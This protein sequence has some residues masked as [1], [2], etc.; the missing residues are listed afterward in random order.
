ML[1]NS[2][3]RM[4]L[5]GGESVNVKKDSNTTNSQ[6]RQGPLA[7]IGYH[8]GPGNLR[9]YNGQ[10]QWNLEGRALSALS[11]FG[12]NARMNTKPTWLQREEQKQAIM[13]SPSNFSF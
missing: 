6:H 5:H 12:E 10:S 4:L 7:N 2:G 9:N 13:E 11:R 8:H 3:Y 1:R